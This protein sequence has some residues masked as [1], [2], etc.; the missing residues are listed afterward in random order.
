MKN[1]AY[2]FPS[3]VKTYKQLSKHLRQTG[4]GV[5]DPDSPFQW[6]NRGKYTRDQEYLGCIICF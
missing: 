4:D 2:Q 3:L 1:T 6:P 5:R